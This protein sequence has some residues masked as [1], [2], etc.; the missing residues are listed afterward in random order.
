MGNVLAQGIIKAADWI[1]KDAKNLIGDL[2]LPNTGETYVYD[3]RFYITTGLLYAMEP[4]RPIQ[5]LHEV[6]MLMLHWHAWLEK[7]EGAYVSTDVVRAIAK[8]FW[9]NELAG[10]FSTYEAK[11]LA[12]KKIQAPPVCQ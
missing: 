4:K 12:A 6:S 8:K 3:P 7:V 9:G 2:V 10:D 11:A 5:Q 1:G